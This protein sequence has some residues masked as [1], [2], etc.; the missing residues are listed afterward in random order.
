LTEDDGTNGSASAPLS[1]G[2]PSGEGPAAAR[3]SYLRTLR[4]RSFSL[5]WAS[6]LISQSGDFIFDVALLWLVLGITHS[7]FA[8]GLVVSGILLPSVFLGPFLGVYVDRW[9]RRR[10]LLAT[11][12]AQGIVTAVL[13]VLVVS[14]QA[15]LPVLFLTVVLLGVGFTIVRSATTAY[16]P[17]VVPLDDLPPANGLLT[18]SSSMNQIV[19]LSI[20]GVFVALLGVTLPIEYDAITFF[21][22]ALLLLMIPRTPSTPA[23]PVSGA[24]PSFREEFREGFSYIRQNR[25]MLEL[26]FVGVLVNF[27]GNGLFALFAPYTEFVLHSSAV[28]Y[29]L[30]GAFLAIGS[31]VG[32]GVMG[33]VNMHDTAGKYLFAGGITLGP[34]CLAIGLTA[35]IPLALVVM[36]IFG[37]ALTVTNLPISVAMQAKVPGRLLGR[38]AASFTALILASSPVGPLFAGWFAER[39]S[40]GAFF[41]L[42]GVVITVVIGASAL[43]MNSL[44]TLRY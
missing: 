10:T 9:D 44:R 39:V 13:A 7:P 21:A 31:L 40:V 14:G 32:A 26:I 6:Q 23:G 41:V 43:T 19:G 4:N 36:L 17:S 22:A 3:P 11:N 35:S 33:K 24:K 5:L 15:T 28:V 12:V 20:G 18:L 2:G 34:L 38:V 25:F 29:G 1:E 42:T 8:V 27:F 30:L 16:V 37:F